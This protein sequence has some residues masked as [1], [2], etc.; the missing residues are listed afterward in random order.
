MKQNFAC[1]IAGAGGM[2]PL[3]RQVAASIGNMEFVA[4]SGFGAYAVILIRPKLSGCLEL[5][6]W[7]N[8][9][10]HGTFPCAPPVSLVLCRIGMSELCVAMSGTDRHLQYG[11]LQLWRAMGE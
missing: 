9:F 6:D 11:V 10:G 5:Q 4:S 2:V 3:R 1:A 8:N 7:Q